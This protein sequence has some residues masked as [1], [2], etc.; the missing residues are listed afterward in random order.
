MLQ[1]FF[2]DGGEG[3]IRTLDFSQKSQIN[4]LK[5]IA[6]DENPSNLIDAIVPPD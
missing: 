3:G 6:Y 5:S 4:S 2:Q 1:L